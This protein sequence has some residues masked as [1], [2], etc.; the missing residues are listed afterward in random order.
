MKVKKYPFN[1]EK[2]CHINFSIDTV[3]DGARAVNQAD[4]T[5]VVEIHHGT[6][7]ITLEPDAYSWTITA[8]GFQSTTSPA[9]VDQGSTASISVVLQSQPTADVSIAVS[10]SDTQ[11]GTVDQPSYAPR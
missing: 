4:P 11:V 10:S 6:G 7:M 1:V 5:Q 3:I 9:R 2:I 8:E